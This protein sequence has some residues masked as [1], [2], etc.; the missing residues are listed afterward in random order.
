[1]FFIRT[2]VLG[3]LI[4]LLTSVSVQAK[5]LSV[6]FLSKNKKFIPLLSKYSTLTETDIKLP[7]LLLTNNTTENIR[8]G[9]LTVIGKSKGSETARFSVRRDSIA[10]I[11]SQVDRQFKAK[12]Q[13]P[14]AGKESLGSLL[15]EMTAFDPNSLADGAVIRPGE[16]AVL[17]LSMLLY[18]HYSGTDHIDTLE[19][20][21]G[22]ESRG[23]NQTVTV[24]VP[25][26][27][28]V[29]RNKY[30]CPVRGTIQIANMPMNYLHHRQCRSQ[31]FGLDILVVKQ[32]SEGRLAT[33]TKPTS[34]ILSDYFAYRKPVLAAGDG[35]IVAIQDAFPE[36]RTTSPANWTTTAANKVIAEL[37]HRIGLLNA[38]YGNFITIMHSNGEYSLYAH[39]S[40]HS[41]KIRIGD[42]VKSGQMIAQV[43]ST[44]NSSEPHLHFQLMDS[45]D[46]LKANGLPI[47]F[48][49]IPADKMNLDFTMV[50]SISCSDNLY[51][52]L[53][54][55]DST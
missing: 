37:S 4:S 42:K 9:D 8:I 25:L 5:D 38:G 14:E 10:S 55:I 31:E 54:D 52:S 1:M 29:S 49:D 35:T 13:D 44:G 23:K 26:D 11:I 41:M 39:L 40:Q 48:T 19:L 20:S 16:N 53:P 32:D 47:V 45:E 2:M 34:S 18:F 15:G 17:L 3:V 46:P 51:L 50:N 28:Y 30:I 7:D 6:S 43:G 21:I 33:C 12:L 24:P 27:Q 36:E 22:Y